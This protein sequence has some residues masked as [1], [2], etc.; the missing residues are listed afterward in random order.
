MNHEYFVWDKDRVKNYIRH[1]GTPQNPEK[2]HEARMEVAS[3]LVEGD[4]VLDVGCGVGHF[5]PWVKGMD[6]LGIDLS[7]D[8]L[9]KAREFNPNGKFEYGD[10]Y[11]LSKFRVFDS[12]V[13]LSLL[14]HL[15]DI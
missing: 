12:V 4:S 13:C 15:P 14:I 6:Y 1:F 8:M 9:R 5:Y 3:Y 11:D 2:K 7:E 10:V